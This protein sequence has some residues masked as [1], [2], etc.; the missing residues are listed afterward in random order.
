MEKKLEEIKEDVEVKKEKSERESKER[1]ERTE[2][3]IFKK[4]INEKII[5]GI[6]WTID[7]YGF[8]NGYCEFL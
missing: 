8:G 6:L 1:K 2:K 5:N 4:R 7:C 3:W